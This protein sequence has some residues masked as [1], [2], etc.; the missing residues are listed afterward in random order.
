M[1]DVADWYHPDEA[2]LPAI[3]PPAHLAP[4]NEAIFPAPLSAPFP[5]DLPIPMGFVIIDET[6]AEVV[7]AKNNA[8]K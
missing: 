8:I 1:L 2:T 5:T 6:A 3:C 7:K 4:V